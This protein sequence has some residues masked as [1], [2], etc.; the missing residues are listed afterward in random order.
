MY[1]NF[2]KLLIIGDSPL[3]IMLVKTRGIGVM[4][5]WRDG[6]GVIEWMHGCINA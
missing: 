6:K 5:E 2:Y 3:T 1:G 4:G